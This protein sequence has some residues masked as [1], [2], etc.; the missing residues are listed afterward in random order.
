MKHWMLWLLAGIVALIGGLAALFNLGSASS[1]T[2]TL[3]GWALIIVG[4]L[5]GW[6]AYK[7]PSVPAMIGAGLLALAGVFLGLSLLFGPFGD[8]RVL[9]FLLGA[10]LMA[11]G[12]TKLWVGRSLHGDRVF[13]VLL[14]V[15]INFG[16]IVALELLASGVGL[17][18]LSLRLKRHAG[19][20]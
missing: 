3:G 5:Q 12:A 17:V 16:L 14:G 8:G 20:N 11:S 1:L 19:E 2:L 10:I 7:A 9:R 6:A 18:L 13:P 4:G 15:T